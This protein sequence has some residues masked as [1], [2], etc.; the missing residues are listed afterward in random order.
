MEEWQIVMVGFFV[1]LFIVIIYQCFIK[2]NNSKREPIP[3]DKK[4]SNTTEIPSN[5]TLLNIDEFYTKYRNASHVFPKGLSRDLFRARRNG[6]QYIVVQNSI[7]TEVDLKAK[8]HWKYEELLYNCSYRNNQGIQLEKE[9]NITEAIKIYE[10]NIAEGFPALHSFNRLMIIYRRL[11][12]YDNEIRV[13]DYSIAL[14]TK[15]KDSRY[16]DDI[17]NW[18][19]RKAKSEILKQKTKTNN[20]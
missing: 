9:G 5:C 16:D 3:Q 19:A 14:F 4:H 7:I 15:L 10:E 17:A 6:E 18:I 1:Y 2:D 11:K 13:I 8:A 12:D 20:I